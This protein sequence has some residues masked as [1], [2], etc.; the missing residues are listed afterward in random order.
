MLSA[1]PAAIS[2]GLLYI[3]KPALTGRARPSCAL[4]LAPLL[5]AGVSCNAL[6]SSRAPA[7]P[8]ATVWTRSPWSPCR[9][10]SGPDRAGGRAVPGMRIVIRSS[11]GEPLPQGHVG[12]IMVRGDGVMS[13][14]FRDPAA[15]AAVPGCQAK[16]EGRSRSDHQA[17]VRLVSGRV[18]R[19]P[20]G[21][22]SPGVPTGY[23]VMLGWA[24]RG[25]SGAAARWPGQRACRFRVRAR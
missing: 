25:S 7:R 21:S 6:V 16:Q 15:A 8:W 10:H 11:T 5:S 23:A 4:S 1:V 17:M 13:G 9:G 14:Y 18:M 20:V 24:G 22:W 2:G 12:E 3:F 19:A